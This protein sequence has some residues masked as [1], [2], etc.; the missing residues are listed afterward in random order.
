MT[1]TGLVSINNAEER[2]ERLIQERLRADVDKDSIDR[3][4]WDLFGEDWTVMCTD[5]A[6]FSRQVL[7]FGVIHF[8]QTIME[9]QRLFVPVIDKHEGILLKVEADSLLLIFRSTIKALQCGISMM[10]AAHNYNVHRP[11]NE[12]I[13]LCLGIGVGTMLRIG[14]HDV[15]GDQVNAASKLG[16]DTA[17]AGDILVTDEVRK[18]C[19]VIPGLTF[20]NLNDVP[21][22]VG[23]AY[24][25]VYH[26]EPSVA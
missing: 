19:G 11:D 15:Y 26:L 1:Y 12:Q 8:L 3:R 16:E 6:G 21:A 10:Q 9:S 25:V 5:L 14:E 20:E 13:L 4:I 17:K 23:A 7:D 18:A 24:N 22:G 2:L